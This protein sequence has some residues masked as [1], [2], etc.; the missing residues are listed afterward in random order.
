MISKQEQIEIMQAHVDGKPIECRASHDINPDDYW[1]EFL[2]EFE[3]DWDH[4]EYRIKLE[5]PPPPPEPREFT[6]IVYEN[7]ACSIVTSEKVPTLDDIDPEKP[8]PGEF[9]KVREVLE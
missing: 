4:G 9:I 5:A 7:G 2:D 6:V 1:K 8:L 3:F